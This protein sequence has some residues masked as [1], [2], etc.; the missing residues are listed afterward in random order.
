M[1]GRRGIEVRDTGQATSGPAGVSISGYHSGDITTVHVHGREPVPW[2][3]Q[4]GVLPREAA[5]FQGRDETDQL[6]AAVTNSGT[7]VLCQVLRG[8]GGV[9]KTQLA[10]H[11]ARQAWTGDELDVLVWVSASSRPAI[12][13]AFAQAAEELLALEPG[14]PER[15]AQAFLRW[16]EPKPPGSEPV[17]RWLV[18][19]DDV[20]DP[21]DVSGLWPAKSP[22]GRT[23]VT[24]RRRDAAL[25]GHRIDLGVFTAEQAVAY[26]VDFLAEH[27]RHDDP[28]EIRA[29]A[30]DLGH[31]PLALSQA[32]AY[33]VDADIPVGCSRCTHRSCPSYRHRLA[34]RATNLANMLP[35]PGTLPDDQNTTVSATWSLSIER[36]DQ[37]N[38]AGLARPTLQLAAMMDP[39]G[40]PQSVLTN[41]PARTYLTQYR[42][43]A[44]DEQSTV[45]EVTELDVWGALRAL[46]RLSLIDHD[47]DSP[48]Q[49]VRIHQLIQRATREA[50]SPQDYRLTVRAAGD[51]LLEG[52][53]DPHLPLAQTLRANAQAVIHSAGDA[54]FSENE[55]HHLL[56]HVG[57]NMSSAG[58]FTAALAHFQ[59]LVDRAQ[60]LLGLDHP[61]TLDARDNLAAN[62][63]ETG[64]ARGAV[65]ALAQLL[66]DRLRIQGPD[67]PDTLNTRSGLA[68]WRGEAG[69]AAGAAEAFAELLTDYLRVQGP[70]HSHTLNARIGL[71][72]WRG[73][74][75]D[76]A[77]AAD[78]LAELLT[79]QLRIQ[80]PNHPE[81]LMTRHRLADWRGRAGDTARATEIFAE[82]LTDR[83]RLQGPDHPDT[84]NDR[85][86]LA[87]WR[88][89][90][91]DEAGAAEAFA[92][93]L[94]DRLRLQGPDHP[95]TLN[96]RIDLAAWRGEAGDAAG[97]AEAFA[98]LFADRL[99]LQGPDHPRTLQARLG[100][101]VWRGEAGDAAEAAESLAELLTDYLRV[102]GPNH[103]DTL[104]ARYWL[105]RLLGEAGDAAGA[106]E[107]LAELLTDHLRVQ[108]ADHPDTLSTQKELAYWM[109]IQ[110]GE[111]GDA[112]GAAEALAALLVDRLA[113]HPPDDLDS[114]RLK[115]QLARWAGTGSMEADTHL[116]ID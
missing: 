22:Y 58:Q 30:Q 94:T 5:A 37:F 99:R 77:G 24:T 42:T 54:L 17:G 47:P 44:A 79:D 64:D 62:R 66:T 97:A 95:D 83:L 19:L 20:A 96:T 2:P 106:A 100:V 7:A 90:L 103:P 78:A 36:A 53:P 115:N 41:G 87:R 55:H 11:Y 93:L 28:D 32:A 110:R 16:L 104:E 33:I 59:D 72:R 45:A 116:S 38:P 9:G 25:P 31:L 27:G 1:A 39:N 3:H 89:K 74:A 85:S 88:G 18:V 29:L 34:D 46:H 6:R 102:Q 8:T 92:E 113:K 43:K 52:W 84:L 40:I 14:D 49:S 91:G 82:L 98:E 4:V 108:G 81:T 73:E 107:S 75:G 101:A 12:V 86:C 114:L 50:L 57:V 56:M 63:G 69:D 60:A 21:A 15:S 26:L 51:A 70:D 80:G 10:A 71:A 35:E 105:A 65:E 67:H 68:R 76:A 23:V 112:A 109:A 48:Q 61:E 111:A 13:S